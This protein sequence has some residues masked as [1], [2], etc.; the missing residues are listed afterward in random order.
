M[1]ITED[2]QSNAQINFEPRKENFRRS[3]FAS[4]SNSFLEIRTPSRRSNVQ[5]NLNLED[6][7]YSSTIPDLK[8]TRTEQNIQNS[9]DRSPTYSQ[10]MSPNEEPSQLMM[11]T[12]ENM[13]EI[14]KEYLRKEAKSIK[15]VEKS[16]WFFSKL[17]NEQRK[18]LENNGIKQWRQWK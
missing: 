3:Y 12:E 6:V 4:S 16:K 11:M 7:D 17:T 1:S 5:S 14:D 15:H 10:M 8:Y 13:F 18:N 9:P 2:G